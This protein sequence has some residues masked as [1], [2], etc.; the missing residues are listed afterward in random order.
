[1]STVEVG[2]SHFALVYDLSTERLVQA[3]TDYSFSMVEQELSKL[4]VFQETSH[5]RQFWEYLCSSRKSLGDIDDGLLLAFREDQYLKA[6]NSKSHRGSKEH[7]KATVNAK[8][9]RIYHWLHWLQQEERVSENTIGPRG[10]VK[11]LLEPRRSRSADA[12]RIWKD[13]PLWSCP[14]LFKRVASKSK[15]KMA[16]HVPT[17]ETVDEIHKLFFDETPDQYVA[18]RNCLF[19]DIASI[20]GFRRASINSLLTSQFLLADIEKANEEY[21]VQPPSQKFSY[22]NSFP[23]PLHLAWQI[24]HFIEGQ[25]ATFIAEK[26][27]Q[28]RVHQDRVFLSSRDGSPITDRSMTHIVSQALRRLG[29]PKGVAL[30]SF[31]PKFINEALASETRYRLEKGLDT[32]ARSIAAAVAMKVGHEDPDSLL[33]YA[34]AIQ[35]RIARLER[36]QLESENRRL[37]QELRLLRDQRSDGGQPVGPRS[38]TSRRPG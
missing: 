37:R 27:V 9:R 29:M 24:F 38:K 26:S 19:V 3:V 31:R 22:V 32:S 33:P 4:T 12:V 34:I 11:S 5:L 21:W 2:G 36:G 30:H 10:K 35:S 25:R 8:L 14:L 18:H 1:M 6:I 17:E 13:R 20:V 16:K 28:K 23:L 15:H 7:A